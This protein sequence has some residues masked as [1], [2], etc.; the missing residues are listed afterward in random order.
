MRDVSSLVSH[1]RGSSMAQ[2]IYLLSQPLAFSQSIAHHFAFKS[3]NRNRD[4]LQEG[5]QQDSSL[6]QAGARYLNF[7]DLG[8]H[9]YQPLGKIL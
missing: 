7:G 5:R 1:F 2:K 9:L 8:L 4:V 6:A 3:A